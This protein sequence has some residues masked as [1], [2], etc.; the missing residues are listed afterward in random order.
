[1][2]VRFRTFTGTI[3]VAWVTQEYMA[4]LHRKFITR[5]TADGVASCEGRG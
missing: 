4:L 5:G 2:R 1:M 3:N